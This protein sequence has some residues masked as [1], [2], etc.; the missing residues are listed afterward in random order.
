MTSPDTEDRLTAVENSWKQRAQNDNDLMEMSVE[1]RYFTGEPM[2]PNA[3][4]AAVRL[5]RHPFLRGRPILHAIDRQAVVPLYT[6]ERRTK[7]ITHKTLSM[8]E[9]VLKQMDAGGLRRWDWVFKCDDDTYVVVDELTASLNEYDPSQPWFI[10]N[11]IQPTGKTESVSGGAGYALSRGL[12]EKWRPH[13]KRCVDEADEETGEDRTINNCLRALGAK[14][15]NLVGLHAH[16]PDLI[17]YWRGWDTADD[18][19][20]DERIITLH[21][22]SPQDMLITDYLM[23]AWH[24]HHYRQDSR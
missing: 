13:L 11:L 19:G 12:L 22:L 5:D 20:F 14:P 8:F 21:S 23:N 7:H 17:E 4:T 18:V 15:I 2:T 9:W 10:G 3:D 1:I 16:S 6:G 24:H